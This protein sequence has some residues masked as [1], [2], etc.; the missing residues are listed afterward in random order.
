LDPWQGVLMAQRLRAAGVEVVEHTFTAAGR[1]QLFGA[2]LDVIRTGR[3]RARPH[4]ELRRELL[5]LE[6]QET[7]AGWRVDHRSGRH[8]DLVVAVAL[9]VAGLMSA[10]PAVDATPSPEDLAALQALRQ[11]GVTVL[12]AGADG[13][14]L[15]DM[16]GMLGA[17]PEPPGGWDN[18]A[19]QEDDGPYLNQFGQWVR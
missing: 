6:V 14:G 8:Y 15:R 3:L 1:R 12:G 11:S 2:L 13:A 17:P 16:A 19:D 7:G 9:A 10:A 5:G 18:L 4:E